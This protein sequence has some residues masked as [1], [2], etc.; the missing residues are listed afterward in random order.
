MTPP[1]VAFL[2]EALVYHDALLSQYTARSALGQTAIYLVRKH[3]QLSFT[4]ADALIRGALV[5]RGAFSTPT[6]R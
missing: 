3:P 5:Q 1:T 2:D 4:A 6:K